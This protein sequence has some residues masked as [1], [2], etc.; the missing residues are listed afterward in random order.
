M[1]PLASLLPSGLLLFNALASTP[2]MAFLSPDVQPDGTEIHI[3]VQNHSK[4]GHR[5]G[6]GRRSF[7]ALDEIPTYGIA[8]DKL[9]NN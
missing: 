4:E 5:R 1:L 8:E 9:S 2:A 6:S 7:L 3:L